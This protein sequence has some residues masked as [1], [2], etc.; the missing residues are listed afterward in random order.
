MSNDALVEAAKTL[1]KHVSEGE[2]PTLVVVINRQQEVVDVDLRPF[3]DVAAMLRLKG[4]RLS[5][6]QV[7]PDPDA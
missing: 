6:E 3:A 7:R 4:R 1:L 5:L 2:K